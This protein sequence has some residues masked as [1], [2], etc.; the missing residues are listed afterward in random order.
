MYSQLVAYSKENEFEPYKENNAELASWYRTQLNQLSVGKLREDRIPK[1]KAIKF[2]GPASRNKW[3]PQYEELVRFR[4]ENPDKWPQYDR[5]NPDSPETKLNVFCQTIRKRYREDDLGDYWFEKMVEIDFN[6]EGKT[7]NWTRY[8]EEVKSII[9]DRNTISIAEI[10]DNAY[11]WIIRHKKLYESGELSNYQS[12]KVSELNLNR[13]FETWDETFSKVETWVQDNNKIPT[14][15]DNKDLNSWLYSQRARFKNGFLTAEQIN[16]LESIGF[17]LE[18]KGKEINE[19]KWLSQFAEYKQFV[20]NNGREPSVVTENKL[21]I[22]VQSQRAHYAGNLRNRNA[23]PQNRLDLLNS[24]GFKWVG[25]GPGGDES[26]EN[27]FLLFS[28]KIDSF[29]N[30]NLPTHIDGTINPL[31]T[32]WF[33]QK[34]AFE[35]G[36]LSEIR[37]NRFKEIGFDF[38]DSKNNSQRDGFTKWS[39]RLIEIA[40]FININ[41]HYPRAGKDKLESNLYQSLARTKRSYKD[42]ELSDKQLELLKKLKIEFE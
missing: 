26:W 23:M 1:I 19:Q 40:D 42:G 13:F 30:I 3:I 4:K 25:E 35:N 15:N 16:C 7:D 10:G 8:Y 22:W 20:E 24:V 31:Y 11:S 17:D 29:G 14:R 21:Y 39:K 2:K 33:N 36:K 32:W 38:N 27:N 12:E 28:Q 41:G 6:F 34:R 9:S 5:E 18:G 37:I